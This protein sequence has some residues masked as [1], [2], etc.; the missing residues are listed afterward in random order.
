V[1][2][3]ELFFK[4][5]GEI[6]ISSGLVIAFAIGFGFI[7]LVG[8]VSNFM[9]IPVVLSQIIAS[10][11]LLFSSKSKLR[12]YLKRGS[13]DI[14]INNSPLIVFGTLVT[15]VFL[16]FFSKIIIWTAGDGAFH[17]SVIKDILMR[18]SIPISLIR[19]DGNYPFYPKLF[20]FFTAFFTELTGVEIIQA[21]KII[22]IIIV[23]M[24]SLGVYALCRE[25]EIEKST[26]V[27]AFII[28]FAIWKHHYPLVWMGYP[29]LTAFLFIISAI[30]VL[31]KEQSKRIPILTF[32]I[33]ISLFFSHQRHFLYIVPIATWLIARYKFRLSVLNSLILWLYSFF[34]IFLT[35]WL[36][37]NV[38]PIP[39]P[40]YLGWLLNSPQLQLE[41]IIL[42]NVGLFGILGLLIFLT[43]NEK[44]YELPAVMLISWLLMGMLIDSGIYRIQT[45]GDNRM[46]AIL[47]IPFSIFSA[48]ALEKI[49][50]NVR[51]KKRFFYITSF[52]IFL[53]FAFILTNAYINTTTTLSWAMSYDDYF[54]MKSLS[55]KKGITINLDPT[56][57]WIYPLS[58]MPLTNP[59]G[60]AHLLN[61]NEIK[62][63]IGDPNSV[64]S[65]NLINSLKEQFGDV[66]MFVSSVS[67]NR[68]GYWIF[69]ERYPE[70]DIN[71]FKLTNYELVFADNAARIY[72]FVEP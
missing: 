67:I 11:V 62:T 61:E 5:S 31:I 48:V 23:V 12:W 50:S 14:L 40:V 8:M 3:E 38:R 27:L 34:G 2:L 56:G 29:Q 46:Y 9:M 35:L 42:W 49:I 36:S 69:M 54:A 15:I 22:P 52:N 17:A 66:Y 33:F 26:S 58:G 59:R 71:K 24:T 60:M 63:I 53:I 4:F 55:E 21:M 64:K 72:K 10:A 45:L 57:Q 20:H 18:K 7:G 68:P 32:F 16:S 43:K 70:V 13:L 41:Q 39:Y 30:L 25:L 47:Y 28:T 65:L 37:G 51:Q 1:F 19:S 6:S 44:I